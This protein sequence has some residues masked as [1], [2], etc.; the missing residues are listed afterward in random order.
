M[1]KRVFATILVILAFC[2][3][4]SQ[5]EKLINEDDLKGIISEVLMAEVYVIN[6][7]DLNTN[8]S[9]DYYSPVLEKYGYNVKDL[10]Y[11]LGRYALR[12]SSVLGPILDKISIEFDSLKRLYDYR[13]E[14]L[15]TLSKLSKEN[16]KKVVYFQD[17]LILKN[18][19]DSILLYEFEVPT[20]W[21]GEYEITY[22]YTI[23]STSSTGAYSLSYYSID[24]VSGLASSTGR[25]W[26]LRAVDDRQLKSSMVVDSRNRD[27]IRYTLP[28]GKAGKGKLNMRI[29]SLMVTF[30]PIDDYIEKDYLDSLIRRVNFSG[31]NRQLNETFSTPTMPTADSAVYEW[32]KHVDSLTNKII[33]RGVDIPLEVKK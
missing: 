4:S 21:S 12:K 28:R 2:R 30:T 1:I 20:Y 27:V 6:N 25:Y 22:N 32:V 7:E 3:C 19:K 10:E 29:D 23:D 26:M 17:S 8:D 31:F 5:S 11:T 9:L 16:A 14:L 15:A 13:G 24:T 18:K 33:K